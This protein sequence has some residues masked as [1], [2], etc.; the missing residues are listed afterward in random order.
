MPLKGKHF[1]TWRA[2]YFVSWV[3]PSGPR[4]SKVIQFLLTVENDTNDAISLATFN[5]ILFYF[6]NRHYFGIRKAENGGPLI[7]LF[8]ATIRLE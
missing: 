1:R 2:R 8:A 7:I 6:C 4:L 5:R 3:P